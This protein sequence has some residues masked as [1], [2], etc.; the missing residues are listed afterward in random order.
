VSASGPVVRGT[1]R[2][3]AVL[4]DPITHSR[5]P[6]LLNAAFRAAGLDAVMVPLGVSAADLG[7]V[8]AALSAVR[9][10]GASVTV[11]H[12]V[13]VA[14]L[15]HEL[16]PAARAIGA[17]NCLAFSGGR[18]HGHNTDAPGFIDGLGEAGVDPRGATA[19]LLG[20]GGAARAVAHGLAEAGAA[21]VVVARDPARV[22]WIAAEPWTAPGLSAALARADLLVDCTAASL[23]PDE[24]AVVASLPLAALRPAARVATLVYHR[25]TL[26]I[27]R[28]RSRGHATIDGRAMLVHQ[29]ARALSIWTGAP[30]PIGAM[31]AALAAAVAAGT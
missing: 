27:E 18:V 29:G 3:A 23:G 28:A 13:A 14:A 6:E 19:V 30:A 12:K 21:V 8:V 26:L 25:S 1:T 7:T 31:T 22:P 4:G 15:C 2:L 20:G 5:S 24:A 9:A 17:V 16:S 11:P 10:L